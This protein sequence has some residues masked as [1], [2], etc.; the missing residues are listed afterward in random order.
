MTASKIECK[1]GLDQLL[2]K[3]MTASQTECKTGLD[4]LIM[5]Y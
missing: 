1:T 2:I 5:G 3:T 4:Q